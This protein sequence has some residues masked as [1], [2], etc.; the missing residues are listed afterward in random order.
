MV[1]PSDQRD[2]ARCRA[3]TQMPQISTSCHGARH[4]RRGKATPTRSPMAKVMVRRMPMRRHG[5]AERPHQPVEQHVDRDGEGDGRRGLQPNS[6][7]SGTMRTLGVA[8]MAGRAEQHAKG[9][10]GGH[11]GGMQ[12]AH[13]CS[14]TATA[15]P[16][17]CD[18]NE[19][20]LCI[21]AWR[22][23]TICG[24]FSAVACRN[25]RGG[26]RARL[27]PA[28]GGHGWRRSRASGAPRS[29]RSS[30]AATW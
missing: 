7:S 11:K 19:C 27:Q 18:R 17:A 25:F 15:S 26:A 20:L 3:P 1:A 29:W 14:C 8:R 12:L 28:D 13:S 22:A 10:K 23:G 16:P 4:V 24:S 5:G 9:R 21:N 6:C 30:P 2:H